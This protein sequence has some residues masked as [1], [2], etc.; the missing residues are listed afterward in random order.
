MPNE[1]LPLASRIRELLEGDI[2]MTAD[3]IVAVLRKEKYHESTPG[4][5][6]N[7]IYTMRSTMKKAARNNAAVPP[8]SA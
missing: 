7:S 8:V 6:K 5:F 2:E 4:V 3:A 1:R